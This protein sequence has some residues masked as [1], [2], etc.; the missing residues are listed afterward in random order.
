MQSYSC[1]VMALK[2]ERGKDGFFMAERTPFSAIMRC[3][4]SNSSLA[5]SE[6]GKDSRAS[7]R[8]IVHSTRYKTELCRQWDELGYCEYSDRCLFAHGPQELK[9][10]PSRHPKYRTQKCSAYHEQGFCSFGPRCSFIHSRPNPED[11]LENVLSKLPSVPLFASHEEKENFPLLGA[12]PCDNDE[13]RLPVF[14][15]FC[16]A[17]IDTL[18]NNSNSGNSQ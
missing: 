5:S 13:N 16:P 1:S 10:L 15:K 14:K 17:R 2:R 12:D 6:S 9:P 7:V 8:S 11:L 18:R 4:S 3:S